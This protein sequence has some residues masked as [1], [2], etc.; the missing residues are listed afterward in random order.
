MPM[1]PAI[2]FFIRCRHHILPPVMTFCFIADFC[3]L[4]H[5]VR[6]LPPHVAQQNEPAASVHAIRD[7]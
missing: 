7:F 4:R 1:L 3:R 2:A 6:L 5:V